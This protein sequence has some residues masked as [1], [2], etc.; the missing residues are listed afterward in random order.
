MNKVLTKNELLN[1]KAGSILAL[2]SI[3]FFSAIVKITVK[4]IVSWL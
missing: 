1:I 3:R 2:P 4:L